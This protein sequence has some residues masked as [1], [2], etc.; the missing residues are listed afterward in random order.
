MDF[1]IIIENFV[2]N[3]GVVSIFILVFLEYANFPI[4]SEVILPMIGVVGKEY[5]IDI[6][7]L[8]LLSTVAG[9][10]GSILN[11]WIGYH[12]GEK[13]IKYIIKKFPKTKKSISASNNFMRKY[14]KLSVL[15]TRF[16]PIAR[17]AISLVAGVAKMNLVEFIVFSTLG[18]F[19]WNYILITGGTILSDL[20]KLEL[21][22]FELILSVILAITIIWLIKKLVNSYRNQK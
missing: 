15:L 6:F 19:I 4:P 16:I 3:Y 10:F 8:I 2:I 12:F 5:N 22:S 21:I 13:V 17:T 7:L 14:S 11:Y 18:I 1:N 20:F 9:L